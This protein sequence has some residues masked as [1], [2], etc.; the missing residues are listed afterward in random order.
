MRHLTQRAYNKG[1]DLLQCGCE[2]LR[3]RGC[4]SH[5]SIL[6]AARELGLQV[7]PVEETLIDMATTLIQLGIA[8]PRMK[9]A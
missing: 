7:T 8:K 2:L 3:N 4:D 6:Q 5:G 1:Y 9:S